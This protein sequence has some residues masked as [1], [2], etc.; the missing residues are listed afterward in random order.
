M[1][2]AVARYMEKMSGAHPAEAMALVMEMT[3]DCNKLI[4]ETQPWKLAKSL[5]SPAREWISVGCVRGWG[6]W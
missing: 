6:R 2:T 1:E 5:P 4:E 3:A